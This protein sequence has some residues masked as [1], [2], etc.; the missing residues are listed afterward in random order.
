[1]TASTTSPRILHQLISTLIAMS[2]LPPLHSLSSS[3]CP[4]SVQKLTSATPSFGIPSPLESINHPS[5]VY[6]RSFASPLLLCMFSD[7]PKC[8]LPPSLRQ[9]LVVL[10]FTNL[11]PVLLR[12]VGRFCTCRSLLRACQY[13]QL[14]FVLL[15]YV[16]QSNLSL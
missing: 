6:S 7:R 4:S 12:H 1:M 16:E 8:R 10:V 9:P 13:V 5:L 3:R 15:R 11:L 2:Y 14:S